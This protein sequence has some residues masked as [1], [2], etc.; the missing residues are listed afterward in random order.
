MN[1]GLIPALK[2][3]DCKFFLMWAN[4]DVSDLWNVH[5]DTY[6]EKQQIQ[7]SGQVSRAELEPMFDRIIEKY[8]TLDSYYRINGKPVF[9]IF[10]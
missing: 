4:H 10:D 2:G 3:T 5:V 8:L 9:S 1:E 7:W 6:W